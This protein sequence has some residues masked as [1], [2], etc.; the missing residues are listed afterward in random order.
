MVWA[1]FLIIYQGQ[2][3]QG[4]NSHMLATYS[5]MLECDNAAV[6]LGIARREARDSRKY[7]Y[8]LERGKY[9]CA[10]IVKQ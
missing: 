4:F 6:D 1:L 9:V 3:A 7:A 5:T 8:P 10:P 2:T